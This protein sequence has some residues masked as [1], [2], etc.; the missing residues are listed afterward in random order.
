LVL[1]RFDALT[2]P[3]EVLSSKGM[4]MN[5]SLLGSVIRPALLGCG[6]LLVLT[7]VAG[8]AYGMPRDTP[9]IDMGSMASAV[10]LLVGG[11]LILRSRR[12]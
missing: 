11:L 5:K 6:L 7:A 1:P 12:T 9:E 3:C 4:V 2:E 10:P 8:T